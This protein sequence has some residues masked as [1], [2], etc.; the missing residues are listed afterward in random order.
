MLFIYRYGHLT[1]NIF[2]FFFI[3]IFNNFKHF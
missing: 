3:V 2:I 1:V